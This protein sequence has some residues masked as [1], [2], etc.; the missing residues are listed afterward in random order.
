M[1]PIIFHIG[2]HKTGT[3]WLQNY[4]FN[5][6]EDI[7]FLGIS[8]ENQ[9]HDQKWMR[10]TFELNPFKFEKD[11]DNIKGRINYIRENTTK[12]IV[13]Y[14]DEGLSGN[15][16]NRG[17]DSLA[18]MKKIYSV[19]P[20]AKIMVCVR[21]QTSATRSFYYQYLIEGGLA[22]KKQ[23]I[24]TASNDSYNSFSF[25]H[26]KYSRLLKSYIKQFGKNNLIVLVYE[27]LLNNPNN[28]I[29]KISYALK[30]NTDVNKFVIDT[31]KK[32][33]ISLN[34]RLFPALRIINRIFPSSQN[35]YFPKWW[36]KRKFS[37]A[38]LFLINRKIEKLSN[39]NNKI[40]DNNFDL[41]RSSNQWIQNEFN[42]NLE[43]FDYL[44]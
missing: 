42:L 6:H 37:E 19:A 30:I 28:F 17:D 25:E 27:E 3:T 4:F 10:N 2:Y 14:S 38:A 1:K 36:P 33:N 18:F 22:N 29:S 21:E 9:T 11:I 34:Y 24:N 5:I 40:F 8:Q 15:P 43:K 13:I 32:I 16:W 12:K 39:S 7:E 44:L 26:L 31:S 23:F 35:P 20:D 41:F